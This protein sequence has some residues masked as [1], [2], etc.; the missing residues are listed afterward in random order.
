[1]NKSPWFLLPA[2]CLALG[3]AACRPALAAA[4]DIVPQGSTLRDA[5]AALART[6]AFGAAETPEDFLGDTLYTREQLARLLTHLVQDDPAHFAKV[7]ASPSA[8]AALHSALESLQPELKTAGVD[9]NDADPVPPGSAAS[10][11]GYVQPELR[12]RTGGSRQPGTGALGVYRVTAL[13][14]LRPNLRYNLS[15]SNWPE[16]DRR[17]FDNDIGPHDFSAVNEAYL[18]LDGG[19]GLEVNLGRMYNRWGP[20]TRGATMVSDNAPALDQI[21]VSFPFSLGARFGHDYRFTQFLSTF[22][23][24]STQK[25][26]A[27][28]RIEYAFS[29]RLSADFQEAYISTASNSLY[30]SLLPDFYS[31]QSANL[32]VGSLRITGL[33]QRYNSFLNFGLS[34]EATPTVRVYG[35][36]GV[37]D[38]QTFGHQSYRTPRKIAQLA[39]VAF[40]PLPQT[41][42]VAEYTFAD[43]TT[44]SSRIT[45]TQWQEGRYDEIGLPDGPNSRA[46][47]VRL[48]Q[49][50]RPGLVAALQGRD[51]RRVNDS[52]PAP[53]SRDYAASVEFSPDHRNSVIVT[54]HDY[55]QDAFP[56]PSSVPSPGDGFTPANA[57]GNY[58]TTERIKQLDLDYRFFF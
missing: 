31:G 32:K 43:P 20:G 4:T 8:A 53:N 40:Q 48:S 58:G 30:V 29:P 51:R 44:Y 12:L 45:E 38:L 18:T 54:Y 23:Q 13:G 24:D 19:R 55:R 2:A 46:L 56:I 14:S 52:F 10:V 26:F 16:D 47:F 21:Q 6:D 22:K 39:G 57:E 50:L 33:D 25:Y 49:R 35:Q 28:R 5:F 1:M 42:I 41:G 9:L 27:G 11:S 15:V 3:S 17:V 37:D 36:L 7:Q 34:Y